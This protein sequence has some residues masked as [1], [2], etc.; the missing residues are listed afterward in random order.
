MPLAGPR[1]ASNLGHAAVAHKLPSFVNIQWLVSNN[2]MP[3]RPLPEAEVCYGKCGHVAKHYRFDFGDHW[4]RPRSLQE[5]S[6][7]R[8]R[9]IEFRTVFCTV[10]DFQ[11]ARVSS[12][13]EPQ[14]NSLVVHKRDGFGQ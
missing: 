3:L 14:K 7:I 12:I 1:L 13:A 8:N 11:N 6:I 2:R 4:L 9:R 10:L 5:E